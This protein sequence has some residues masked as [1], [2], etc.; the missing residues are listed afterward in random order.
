MEH[1]RNRLL[2]N[3]DVDGCYAIISFLKDPI[4]NSIEQVAE[5]TVSEKKEL[6][7]SELEK[8]RRLFSDDRAAYEQEYKFGQ[9][10][11]WQE[12]LKAYQQMIN[13]SKKIDECQLCPDSMNY[14]I[15]TKA[16]YDLL[17]F[18]AEMQGTLSNLE[19]VLGVDRFLDHVSGT[20]FDVLESILVK[21][22]QV[23]EMKT[24]RYKSVFQ[25]KWNTTQVNKVIRHKLLLRD[26]NNQVCD[27]IQGECEQV[28]LFVIDGFGFSQYLWNKGFGAQRQ[29]YTFDEN[30]FR[31]LSC[32]NLAKELVL[33]SSFVTD[34]GAG[35]A[36]IYLG[37]V[38]GETGIIA[39]KVKTH[40]TKNA[41]IATKTIPSA[42]F[43]ELFNYKN[44]IT[45]LVAMEGKPSVIYYCSRYQEPPSGFSKCIFK[46][47]SVQSILPAERV[48][49]V[50]LGDIMA[51]EKSGLQVV[52]FT[53]ID[54][55]GH[56]MGAYS[57]FERYEHQ[58]VG[59]LFRNL[60]IELAINLPDLFDGRRSVLITADHGMF[61]SSKKIVSRRELSDYLYAYGIKGV[62]LVEN[63]RAML[64]YNEGHNTDEEIVLLA[65]QFFAGKNLMVDVQ[66]KKSE[67]F[68]QCLA[69]CDEK[70]MPDI[71][72]RFVGEGLFYSNPQANEHLLHFGGHGGYSV[73]EVFVPLIEVNLNDE[74]LGKIK[75]R[76][77]SRK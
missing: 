33:G 69:G 42:E 5:K 22:K 60:L 45:D 56:T 70:I 13:L 39:S 44:S 32:E 64:F 8:I 16:I 19:N 7:T 21:T 58:K 61:E 51:G 53:G 63:N 12:V 31:W 40:A 41:F 9:A 71:V 34:T 10:I 38:S 29:N 77:L 3:G 54:N 75:K 24:E 4:H 17:E 57:K 6:V 49:S 66:S 68:S 1:L 62:K 59:Y 27:L 28:I 73:D 74:L 25:S 14:S 72:A 37:Q 11:I 18:Y 30:I 15:A 26:T 43:D 55:S 76:F 48:F 36:Q 65:N 52:Y 67:A 46:S 20:T 47:A 35:L 50:L 23:V 2:Q